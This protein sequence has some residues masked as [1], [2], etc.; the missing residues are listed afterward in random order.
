MALNF[1]ELNGALDAFTKEMKAKGF[2]D[3]VS[4]IITSDFARTLTANSGEGSDHAWGGN[5]FV[6]GGSVRGGQVLGEYPADITQDGPYNVGR[7]R[8]IPTSSWESILQSVA[9]WM[10]VETTQELDY[11]LPNRIQTGTTLYSQEEVFQTPARAFW[12]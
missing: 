9:E 1:Q 5:Y 6:M 3:N 7:G 12:E 10:G 4:L 11:C 8:L 2:W